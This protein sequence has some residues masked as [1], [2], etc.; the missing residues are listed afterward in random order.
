MGVLIRLLAAWIALGSIS[1]YAGSSP[2]EKAKFES[3]LM[4][5][6][7]QDLSPQVR[8]LS[9]DVG[10]FHWMRADLPK[11]TPFKVPYVRKYIEGVI[12]RADAGFSNG[13][14]GGGLYLAPDPAAL[15]SGVFGHNLIQVT[16]KKGAAFFEGSEN[17]KLAPSSIELINKSKLLAGCSNNIGQTK[18]WEAMM[19]LLEASDCSKNLSRGFYRS[20]LKKLGIKF[21]TYDYGYPNKNLFC[22]PR[23]R[24]A[25]VLKSAAAID[26]DRTGILAPTGGNAQPGDDMK[27]GDLAAQ[28]EVN[29]GD[30]AAQACQQHL[31]DSS[32]W[33][34]W[35]FNGDPAFAPNKLIASVNSVFS[36][37]RR[38]KVVEKGPPPV[39][40]PSNPAATAAWAKEHWF[41]CGAYPEDQP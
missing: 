14:A 5:A 28:I 21:F 25:F 20:L 9:R 31:S 27:P 1:A 10:F 34:T 30:P 37:P 38:E 8:H 19:L 33:K 18:N 16:L 41:S 39:A 15:E 35:R 36:F 13:A 22:P 7:V 4:D 29:A 32:T 11:K 3:A 24:V 23:R 40:V 6:L 17:L 2:A 12:S 26:W